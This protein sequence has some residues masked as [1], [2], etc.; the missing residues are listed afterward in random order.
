[1][2]KPER[3]TPNGRL[4]RERKLRGWTQREVGDRVGVD[5]KVVSTWER[6]VKSPSAAAR[7]K[8]CEL[9]GKSPIELGFL[10]EEEQ[11]DEQRTSRPLHER[12]L[13][14]PPIWNV[15]FARNPA[16]TGR[17]RVLQHLHDLLTAAETAAL[18]QAMSGLGGVGKTQI[19]VEYCYRYRGDYR[20]VLWATADSREALLADLIGI[21]KLLD[22]PRSRAGDRQPVLNALRRWMRDQPRWLLVVDNLESPETLKDLIPPA[23]RGHILLTTRSQVTG[24]LPKIDVQEMDVDE[25]ALLVLRRAHMLPHGA[26]L[27]EADE[28][29]LALARQVS[30]ELGSL[31]LALDQAGAYLQETGCSLSDYL[32][33]YWARRAELLSYRGALGSDHP[34]SV[35][36]TLSLSFERIEQANVTAADLLRACAFLHPE[37]IPEEFFT[38]GAS[39][40]G[41]A[42]QRLAAHPASLDRVVGD[43]LKYSLIRRNAREKTLG[44]HRLV[45][46][47]LLDAMGQETQRTW[48]ERLV[49]AVNR[50]LLEDEA[51]VESAAQRYLLQAQAC[52]KL[53]HAWDCTFVEAAQLVASTARYFHGDGYYSQAERHCLQA[54]DMFR[55]MQ[56]TSPLDSYR[57][58]TIL[59]L[60]KADSGA[61]REAEYLCE[62]LRA[63]SQ[64]HFGPQHPLTARSQLYLARI[65]LRRGKFEQ[66]EPLVAHALA[67][68]RSASAPRGFPPLSDILLDLAMVYSNLR[69]ATQAETLY[70]EALV[71]AE[72]TFGAEHAKVADILTELAIHYG[73][74]QEV[75]KAERLRK[76]ALEIY[77]RVFPPD[78]P[79]IASTLTGLSLLYR[80]R[81]RYAEA[82][83]CYRQALDIWKRKFRGEFAHPADGE[84]W[85]GGI[86]SAV[87]GSSH[88]GE[89]LQRLLFPGDIG[90]EEQAKEAAT[91]ALRL[92]HALLEQQKHAEAEALYW[93]AHD[94][95]ERVLGAEDL[96]TVQCLGALAKFYQTQ[97]KYRFAEFLY[98]RALLLIKEK[99][100]PV[101]E[102]SGHIIEHY[103]QFLHET[104][105]SDLL[106][107]F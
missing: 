69:R 85:P 97:L 52:V 22:L 7:Q 53:V 58:L 81:R 28:T 60:I 99:F 80:S 41:P 13:P 71:A 12:E 100:Q 78:H 43:L 104:G 3:P 23:R 19:A 64:A 26:R 8:L 34:H 67:L 39:A 88:S 105:R 21:A 72:R 20:A 9:F 40:L 14:F 93:F 17:E 86:S 50:A 31:P 101:P 6:G 70:Q 95:S 35:A 4:R 27:S 76:R 98:E 79:D 87:E 47:V 55:S 63:F 74:Q 5:S 46:A 73:S 44:I 32:E 68:G 24:T 56:G 92:A 57:C 75:E 54:M 90:Q 29:A 61:L 38:R 103:L 42:L 51:P 89:A 33:L 37:A 36:T 1:M 96:G 25:G 62:N 10:P 48:A 102:D 49:R 11:S 18:T 106:E 94:L 91:A 59:M 83:D 82:E 2:D 84:V 15:P 45:Q 30:R 77:R 66:A 65:Y 16:F 107:R